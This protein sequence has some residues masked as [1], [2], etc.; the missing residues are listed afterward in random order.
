MSEDNLTSNQLSLRQLH[1]LPFILANPSISQA[2]KQC[3]VSDKQI[4]DWLNQ[5]EFRSELYR[6]RT[7]IISKVTSNLQKASLKASEI[8]I[9]LME[10]GKTDTIKHKAAVDLLNLTIKFTNCYELEERIQKLEREK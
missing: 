3:G 9:E 5:E 4:W 6:Q 2:A 10:N 7:S 1:A 8:L